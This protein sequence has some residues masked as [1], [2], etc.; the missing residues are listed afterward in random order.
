MH[1]K[2]IG[3]QDKVKPKCSWYQEV[4]IKIETETSEIKTKRTINR[5]T[6]PI[7]VSFKKLTRL[8]NF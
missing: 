1:L 6:N 5:I 2:T 3:K 4:I 8:A 7:A